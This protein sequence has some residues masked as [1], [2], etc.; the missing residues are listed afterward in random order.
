M[1][2]L[3]SAAFATNDH[4]LI[5]IMLGWLKMGME[6]CISAYK[7]LMKSVFRG[8][9]SWLPTDCKGQ[10]KPQFGSARLK[11]AIEE[12]GTHQGISKSAFLN[13]KQSRGCRV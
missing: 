7:K 10:I 8:K 3:L 5:A 9:S 13:D 11:S 6:E 1:C 2:D 12:L 4:R